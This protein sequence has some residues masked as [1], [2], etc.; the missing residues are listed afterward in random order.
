MWIVYNVKIEAAYFT[1]GKGVHAA[2]F[3]DVET[4]STSKDTFEKMVYEAAKN[5]S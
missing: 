1:Y 4:L 3:I 5:V 2:T